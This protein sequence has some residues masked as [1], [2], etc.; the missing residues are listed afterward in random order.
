MQCAM[1][2]LSVNR[3]L[4]NA[5][6]LIAHMIREYNAWIECNGVLVQHKCNLR[7][8]TTF[9]GCT[10]MQ[11]GNYWRSNVLVWINRQRGGLSWKGGVWPLPPQIKSLNKQKYWYVMSLSLHNFK[12][13]KMFEWFEFD[14]YQIHWKVMSPRLR[15][16]MS[17]SSDNCNAYP[18]ICVAAGCKCS[19]NIARPN[20]INSNVDGSVHH[21][22][23]FST[24]R[25]T[26]SEFRA[27]LVVFS[28]V[29][30]LNYLI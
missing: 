26:L 1:H 27:A 9:I 29:F 10:R 18:H 20:V 23:L 21:V 3:I 11:V 28:Y 19:W 17:P 12:S 7:T 14:S 30:E 4:R 15:K 24:I 16:V 6:Y 2:C 5:Q 13:W 25:E 22:I 8:V